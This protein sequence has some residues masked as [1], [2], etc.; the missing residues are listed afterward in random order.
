MRRRQVRCC[1]RVSL[2]IMLLENEQ[3]NVHCARPRGKYLFR[4]ECASL[5]RAVSI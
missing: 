3:G 2:C 5:C 4:R 1:V